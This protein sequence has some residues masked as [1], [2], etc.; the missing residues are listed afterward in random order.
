MVLQLAVSFGITAV[1]L[2]FA[3][4]G[5]D[6]AALRQ[7]A[8]AIQPAWVMAALPVYAFGFVIRLI[9]WRMLIGPDRA[10]VW[11][12]LW[13]P[14]FIGFMANNLLP[15]RVGELIR[16]MVAGRKLRW[17]VSAAFGTL[18]VE[19]LS[20]GLIFLAVAGLCAGFVTFPPLIATGAAG[21][22]GGV[23]AVFAAVT[24]FLWKRSWFDA[25][26]ARLPVPAKFR[27]AL[28]R[29]LLRMEE[30]AGRVRRPA[31]AL[32]VLCLS[33][34]AW[35]TES[36]FL[37]LMTQAL[38]LSLS[39]P[40]AFFLLFSLGVSVAL[41]QAPGYFGPYELVGSL[42][43]GVFGIAKDQG[44]ATILVIHLTQYLFILGVGLLALSRENLNLFQL[45]DEAR[46]NPAPAAGAGLAPGHPPG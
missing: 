31:V 5:V 29:F 44:V 6:V 12:S 17:S 13:N 32:K 7:G 34:A 43:L 27:D 20:D 37:L 36:V 1:C 38:G 16:A 21:M 2:Y 24:L 42:A 30:G 41:P 46:K 18:M 25:V 23:L 19:R 26:V 40:Q 33:A 45:A 28:T 15:L 11:T 14:L 3:F 35:T 8:A 4:Q 22:A 10:P 39:W 9:R